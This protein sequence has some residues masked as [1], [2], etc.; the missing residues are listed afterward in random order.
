MLRISL[1]WS[2][3]CVRSCLGDLMHSPTK[4]MGFCGFLHKMMSAMLHIVTLV[5]EEPW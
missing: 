3:M 5:E 4:R 2:E 1:L